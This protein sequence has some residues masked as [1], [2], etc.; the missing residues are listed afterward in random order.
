MTIDENTPGVNDYR[1]HLGCLDTQCP[2]KAEVERLRSRL[3]YIQGEMT[4]A[5]AVLRSAASAPLRAGTTS[6]DAIQQGFRTPRNDVFTDDDNHPWFWRDV[7]GVL[8][9]DMCDRE[10]DDRECRC[11]R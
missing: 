8:R 2:N 1:N 3:A 9:C 11:V 6:H 5:A 10:A 4:H 7:G